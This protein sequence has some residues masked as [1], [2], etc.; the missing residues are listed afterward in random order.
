MIYFILTSKYI[1]CYVTNEV[2]L[3]RYYFALS[4]D[5]LTLTILKLA[6]ISFGIQTLHL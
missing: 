4:D 5:G 3:E 1:P 2:S 6:Y